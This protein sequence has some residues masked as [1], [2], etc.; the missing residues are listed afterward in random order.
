MGRA[1]RFPRRFCPA[2]ALVLALAWSTMSAAAPFTASD[3][4]NAYDLGELDGG[5][6]GVGWADAW[7]VSDPASQDRENVVTPPTQPMGL[8]NGS[9]GF[10]GV[11]FDGA[12]RAV[13]ING[14]GQNNSPIRRELA[15]AFSGDSLYFSY[16]FRETSGLD[17]SDFF[18]LWLDDEDGADDNLH[19]DGSAFLGVQGQSGGR[20]FARLHRTNSARQE[21]LA[22]ATINLGD[23]SDYLLVGRLFRDGGSS[24]YNRLTGWL[25]P[26][27]DD[28]RDSSNTF[29]TVEFENIGLSSVTHVGVRTGASTDPTDVYLFDQLRLGEHPYAVVPGPIA[30]DDFD[31]PAGE[32]NSQTGGWGFGRDADH[33]WKAVENYTEVVSMNQP[34][35]VGSTIGSDRAVEMTVDDSEPAI[36]NRLSRKFAETLPDDFYFSFLGRYE[37]LDD[38]DFFAL[39][40]DNNG[41]LGS[42][43]HGDSPNIGLRGGQVYTRLNQTSIEPWAEASDGETFL[44]VGHVFSDAGTHTME[45]WLNPTSTNAPADVTATFGGSLPDF[46]HMG[47]RMGAASDGGDMLTID[48]IRFGD[49]LAGVVSVPE[50]SSAILCGLMALLVLGVPRHRGMGKRR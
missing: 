10:N 8:D 16:L 32:L 26:T 2:A 15:T 22:P 35:Q 18:T 17:N 27:I 41:S 30:G 43:S 19:T 38:D 9:G 49:S 13:E 24:D 50:P 14:A 21:V 20:G 47:I 23:G 6:A 25:N 44:L 5:A 39:W 37:G 31:L 3:S 40:L 11:P 34:L 4:F 29:G 33:E 1:Q 7:V 46:S 45:A 42:D 36:R 28:V 48:R 12:N